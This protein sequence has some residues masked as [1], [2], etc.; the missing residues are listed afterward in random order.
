MKKILCFIIFFFALTLGVSAEYNIVND[1]GFNYGGNKIDHFYDLDFF[2]DGSYVVV[3][4]TRS[5][6]REIAVNGNYP[7]AILAIFDNNNNLVKEWSWGN[8]EENSVEEFFSVRVVDDNS[9]LVLA[10]DASGT[11][12]AIKYNKNGTEM[13]STELGSNSAS[14]D[15]YSHSFI[16]I[17]EDGN[18]LIASNSLTAKKIR[19]LNDAG[20][21]LK[22]IEFPN[23]FSETNKIVEVDDNYIVAGTNNTAG[24]LALY[25]VSKE[26][27]ITDTQVFNSATFSKIYD[28]DVMGDNLLLSLDAGICSEDCVFD[29]DDRGVIV[30]VDK[31]YNI[32]KKASLGV[33]SFI[34]THVLEDKIAVVEQVATTHSNIYYFDFDLNLLA[35]YEYKINNGHVLFHEAKINPVNNTLYVA[36]SFDAQYG[37]I[38]NNGDYDGVVMSF[39]PVCAEKN[40]DLVLDVIDD[41]SKKDSVDATEEY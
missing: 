8:G 14:I 36:A 40:D 15:T 13:W 11:K 41:D 25:E 32:I 19:R 34:S 16:Y 23:Y 7:D 39:N 6:F 17:E 26:G 30:I 18:Y 3:G 35:K 1:V 38:G 2:S 22:D 9:F 28:I 5:T 21:I 29:N 33:S 37:N 12:Y 10:S 24:S 4:D 31:G 20:T 27:T